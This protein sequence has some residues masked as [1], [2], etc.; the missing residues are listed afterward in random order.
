VNLPR[1]AASVSQIDLLHYDSDK[2]FSGREFAIDLLGRKLTPSSLVMMDDISD[3]G[4]FRSYV[5]GR[6]LP[7]HVMDQRYGV[8]GTIE[9]ASVAATFNTDVRA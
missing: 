2:S 4:W 9:A 7:F 5:G 8:I 1:I 6:G 3:D